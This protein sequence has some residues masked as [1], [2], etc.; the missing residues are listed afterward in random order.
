MQLTRVQFPVWTLDWFGFQ[1]NQRSH[2]LGESSSGSVKD[3][4]P[5]NEYRSVIPIPVAD[6]PCAAAWWILRCHAF[7]YLKLLSLPFFLR[8]T[9]PYFSHTFYDLLTVSSIISL[10]RFPFLMLLPFLSAPKSISPASL[11]NFLILSHTLLLLTFAVPV[12]TI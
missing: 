7:L 5:V 1:Y 3:P 11:S 9:V 4:I 10:S 12:L 8:H 2:V 6:S